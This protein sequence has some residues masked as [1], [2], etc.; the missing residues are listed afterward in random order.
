MPNEI[1]SGW[2]SR[3]NP[4]AW[5]DIDGTIKHVDKKYPGKFNPR[6]F[7]V[8]LSLKEIAGTGAC[9]D[10][11]P[12]ELA[13]FLSQML[14]DNGGAIFT[15]PSVLEGG[16]VLVEKGGLI[17]KDFQVLTSELA[18]QEMQSIISMFLSSWIAIAD[19]SDGWGT[20]PGV[21][22]PVA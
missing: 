11:S 13:S 15:G 4:H 21:S 18:K 6:V 16:H 12:Y 20:L 14:P 1:I 9:T 22:T 7:S 17:N 8:L 5:F 3:H 2:L 10:Q 19:N